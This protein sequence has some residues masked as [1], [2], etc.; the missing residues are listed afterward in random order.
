M[1]VL[2]EWEEGSTDTTGQIRREGRGAKLHKI[3]TQSGTEQHNDRSQSSEDD[4]EEEKDLKRR[5]KWNGDDSRRFLCNS[6]L[7]GWGRLT[8]T[9]RFF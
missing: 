1:I 7:G 6:S 8:H 5:Q 3:M 9:Q 2:E 4:K